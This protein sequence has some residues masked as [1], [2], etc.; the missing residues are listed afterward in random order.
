MHKTLK[1]KFKNGEFSPIT[2]VNGI[3]EG[4][5]VEVILKKSTKNLEFVGMWRDRD[6]I[7]SGLEYVKKVRSWSRFN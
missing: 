2:P 5:T 7:K 4:E 3:E 1:V 6:D